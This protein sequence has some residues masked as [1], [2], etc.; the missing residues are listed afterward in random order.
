MSHVPP[1]LFTAMGV[2]QTMLLE[3]SFLYELYIIDWKKQHEITASDEREL[4]I[5]WHNAHKGSSFSWSPGWH[6][7]ALLEFG[8]GT[9]G[10]YACY[11]EFCFNEMCNKEYMKR[12]LGDNAEL[13]ELYARVYEWFN[14]DD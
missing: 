12:L 4:V 10:C 5:A 2:D 14:Q 9:K 7:N 13:K 3:T 8:Y 6:G 11:N 1:A